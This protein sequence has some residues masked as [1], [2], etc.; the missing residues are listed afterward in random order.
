M[1]REGVEP[2]EPPLLLAAATTTARLLRRAV[3]YPARARNIGSGSRASPSISRGGRSTQQATAPVVGGSRPLSRPA[4]AGRCFLSH[5]PTL[6]P[7][8]VRRRMRIRV[9]RTSYVEG[10]WS[11]SRRS[12]PENR[13]AK[14]DAY[15]QRSFPTRSAAGLSLSGGASI[16]TLSSQAGH[17]PSVRCSRFASETTKATLPDRPRCEAPVRMVPSAHASLRGRRCRRAG[18]RRPRAGSSTVSPWRPR[19]SRRGSWV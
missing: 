15:S 3:S 11:P 14:A 10:L 6:R 17:H 18:A 8:I 16:R 4:E 2:F 9:V 13:Q 7:W 12:L 1:D 5:S 19:P